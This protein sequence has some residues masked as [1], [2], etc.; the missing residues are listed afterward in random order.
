MSNID[1]L[2]LA[3][4]RSKRMGCE[5][6][7]KSILGGKAL[8]EIVVERL[9]PQVKE[10]FI[11]AD[12]VLLEGQS[13]TLI[14]DH[15]E[16]FLGP[17][18]GLW[19]ALKSDQLSTAN[20]LMIAPCDGPFIPCNLVSELYQLIIANDADIACV[21]Y[22]GFA[23]PTFSLWHKR[24]LPAVE[25]TL[26]VKKQGGFKPLLKELNTVYF[27]WPEQPLNPFFNINT[28]AD[29]AEAERLLA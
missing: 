6:K 18:T 5:N 28:P 8:L 22:Q 14:N 12:P 7:L 15:I 25:K 27:D 29:L 16:G 3:A 17:L 2:I 24:V 19:S 11:N 20:Y 26:L 23:Q 4:G 10:L 13:L 1:G 21:R 9:K